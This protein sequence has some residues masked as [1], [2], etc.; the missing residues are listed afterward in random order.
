MDYSHQMKKVTKAT[1]SACFTR[2][3]LSGSAALVCLVSS[4]GF[5]VSHATNLVA[6][7]DF[8]IASPDGPTT[9]A[10]DFNGGS[11]PSA[12]QDWN[13]FNDNASTTTTELVPAALAPPGGKASGNIMHVTTTNIGGYDGI[14]QYFIPYTGPTGPTGPAD[15][16]SCDWIY[17]KHGAVG[18]GTGRYAQ[19]TIDATLFKTGSWEVLNV[20][21]IFQPATNTIIYSQYGPADFFVASVRVSPRSSS[22]DKCAPS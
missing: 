13:V 3:I 17:I 7:G 2:Q 18:I 22:Q 12:A 19:T 21:N 5:E 15:V 10:T 9:L 4:A 20:G 14:Y 16:L 11:G 1:F 8:G 6:N